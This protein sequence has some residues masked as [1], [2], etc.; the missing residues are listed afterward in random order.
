M[1][2]KE[3]KLAS[4]IQQKPSA[5]ENS[6]DDPIDILSPSGGAKDSFVLNLY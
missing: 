3:V 6:E 4:E 2:D 1:T 5:K